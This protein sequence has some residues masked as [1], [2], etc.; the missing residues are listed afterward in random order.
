MIPLRT[1]TKDKKL[2]AIIETPYH[3]RN[4]YS[5]DEDTGLYK[6]KKLLPDGMSFPCDMGFIPGTK[7]DDGDPLDILILMDDYAYPGCWVECRLLGGIKAVQIE[8]GKKARNDRFVAVPAEVD[9]Y[10]HLNQITDLNKNKLK[11][12][13]C[14]FENYNK[15]EKKEFKFLEIM[16]AKKAHEVIGKYV[17]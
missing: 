13:V 1:Y 11:S 16:S 17:I 4:K 5:Y 3:S 9:E 6:F 12:I 10:N 2:N 7:G 15:L 14:F 8:N